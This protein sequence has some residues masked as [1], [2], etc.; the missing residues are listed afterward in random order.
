MR[1]FLEDAHAHRDDGYGRAQKHAQRQLPKRF[2]KTADVAEGEGGLFRVLLDGKPIKTPGRATV[3]MPSKALA[4]KVAGEWGS[5]GEFIDPAL[6]PFTRLVNTSVESGEQV[7]PALRA[8]IVKYAG[9]D[10]L[11]YR[12]DGPD[13]L[14]ERQAE[15]WDKALADFARRFDIRFVA[16]TGIMHQQQS[17]ETLT[18]V[19]RLTEG[20]GVFSL[21]AVTSI[22]AIT[23]SAVLSLGLAHDLFE[24]DAAWAAAHVDEDF[25]ISQWGEDSEAAARRSKRREDYDAALDI[26]GYVEASD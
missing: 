6:M 1:E 19:D 2:Y 16:T 8:E 20:F 15:H 3:E 24:R 13:S 4:E 22:T 26:L 18:R 5:Q 10:L 21:M 23:G 12:A 14:V 25:N 17:E 9:T 7:I 11:L